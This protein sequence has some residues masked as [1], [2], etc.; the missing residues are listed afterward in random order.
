MDRAEGPLGSCAAEGGSS[1]SS[2]RTIS[3]S[4]IEISPRCAGRGESGMG[5]DYT[6]R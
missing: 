6:D 5:V 1:A 3:G 2:E 4:R